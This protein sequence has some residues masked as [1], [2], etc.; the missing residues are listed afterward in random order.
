MWVETF[1]IN[2]HQKLVVLTVTLIWLSC[3]HTMG[4]SP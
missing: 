2:Q 3:D 1:C 4:W